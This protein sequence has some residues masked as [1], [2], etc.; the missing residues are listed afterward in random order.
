MKILFVNPD[1]PVTCWTMDKEVDLAGYDALFPPLGLLTVAALLPEE[2]DKKL[3]D[4]NIESL[5][6]RDI[7]EADYVFIGGMNVQEVSMREV[8]SRAKKLNKP[9][10]AGG[11]L[12]THEYERFPEIDYLVLNEAEITL[13]LFLEDLEKGEPKKIYTTSEFAD[14]HETPLPLWHL[15]K[16]DRY[17]A[18]LIQY[19]RGC[20]YMCDFCDVTSLFGRR[21]RT[22]TAEQIIRELDSIPDIESFGIIFFADDNLIGNKKLVKQELLPELKT[23]QDNRKTKIMLATQLTI[24]LA[25][26]DEMMTQMLEAGFGMVFIGLETPDED[27]LALCRKKQNTKRNLIDNVK[28]LQTSGFEVMA[29]FILGFDNDDEGVFDRQI[30]FIQESGIVMCIIGLLNAPP[31]TELH[32]RMER[33]NRL[34]DQNWFFE[35][36]TNIAPKMDS[37]VLMDGF[38]RTVTYLYNGE[39]FYNRVIKF[40]SM[41]EK[42]AIHKKTKPTNSFRKY[43]RASIL[44]IYRLGIKNFDRKYFWKALLWSLKNKPRHMPV[45][46][47]LYAR[48]FHFRE[49]YSDNAYKG[50]KLLEEMKLREQ[51][52]LSISDTEINQILK[53]VS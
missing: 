51:R 25:D 32:E 9:I 12:L 18:N 5:E 10:V 44:I 14:V 6:D 11:P 39:G 38:N 36:A 7:L 19:S 31:G 22:K 50:E 33:E 1:M 20:P 53:E 17:G 26:D 41:Y 15:A 8:I 49:V 37:K 34:L 2:W 27:T 24:T 30:E 23:W 43:V 48:G 40:L 42:P 4:L 3:V 52:N 46:A 45:A 29:G 16:L 21:P 13:P 47:H 28:Y 35:G